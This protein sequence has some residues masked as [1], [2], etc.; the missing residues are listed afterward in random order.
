MKKLILLAFISTFALFLKAATIDY[1][2]GFKIEL[3]NWT[4]E[5][6]V[7][8]SPTLSYGTSS[9]LV[10]TIPRLGTL[11]GHFTV[12]ST[13]G[14]RSFTINNS[15]EGMYVISASRMGS[16]TQTQNYHFTVNELPG[17]DFILRFTNN[18]QPEDCWIEFSDIT[19]TPAPDYITVTFKPLIGSCSD[20]TRQ[21]VPGEAYGDFPIPKRK[22]C[23]F[24]GWSTS[25]LYENKNGE[26]YEYKYH[27]NAE[28]IVPT[29]DITLYACWDTTADMILSPDSFE[30]FELDLTGIDYFV[31]FHNN[32][33]LEN[34]EYFETE[35]T[36]ISPGVSRKVMDAKFRG[37]G[38]L[39]FPSTRCGTYGSYK[40]LLDGK[41]LHY[42]DSHIV[43]VDD[44]G[45]HHLT[46]TIN[47]DTGKNSYSYATMREILW[48][49]EP[50]P[51][52][53]T[54]EY[55]S[56]EYYDWLNA[57]GN[58]Y[59][60][61]GDD[62][63]YLHYLSMLDDTHGWPMWMSFVAGVN[64]YDKDSK[65]TASIVMEGGRPKISINPDL[66]DKRI[67]IVHGSNDLKS[68]NK[69]DDTNLEDFRFFK[70]EVKMP[71][72]N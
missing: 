64:P 44:D 62:P 22:G 16:T 72:Q 70:V 32:D 69:V 25:R 63:E 18:Y 28:S 39:T 51:S 65:L 31:H 40:L 15:T 68:W 42:V 19:W 49:P 50:V 13:S 38:R 35:P 4:Y 59:E 5:D 58:I 60:P 3:G 48:R 47:N 71:E 20:Q 24:L 6:G 21:Y 11:D 12:F 45:E 66:G 17:G 54:E 46:L 61:Y 34:S 27:V 8:R 7:Y 41:E 30:E 57:T 67:Y 23:N 56:K 53:I 2:N 33:S 36:Y 26:P 37:T 10:C 14:P 9:D 55:C 52:F 43:R 29:K 1:D